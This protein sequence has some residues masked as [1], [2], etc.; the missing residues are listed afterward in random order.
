ML[1]ASLGSFIGAL[2][3]R[4]EKGV[5]IISPPSFCDYCGKKILKIDLVPVFSF[6]FLRG[7]TRC[8]GE[9]ISKDK[10][11][12]ELLGGLGFV[13]IFNLYG[14]FAGRSPINLP[15]NITYRL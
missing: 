14:I 7:K 15:I 5:S 6:L 12:V 11:L 8:C 13:F 4:R 10:V 2:V 1:G 9:K 3:Y